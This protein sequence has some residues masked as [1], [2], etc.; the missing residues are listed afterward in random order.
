MSGVLPADHRLRVPLNDE[1]HARPPEPLEAPSRLSYLVLLSDAA[2]R[3]AGFRAICGL[4]ARFDAP[5]PAEGANH[6]RADL[7]PFRLKWERHSEFVRYT[8]IV[9]GGGEETALSSVPADWVAALPGELLVA[10][11]VTLLAAGTDEPFELAARLFARE[12]LVGAAV[13][14]ESATAFADFRIRESGFSRMLVRDDHLTPAQAGRIVQRLL[15]IDTYRMMALLALP[16][17]QE[18]VPALAHWEQELAR[19]TASMV[20]ATDQDEP[21]LLGGLTRL[22]AEIDSRQ[23]DNLYRFSATAAYYDLVKQRIADLRETRLGGLQTFQ[24]FTE[25]RLA[26]AANTCRSVAARQEELSRRV[27]RATQL[28]ATRVGITH[29]QQNQALLQSVNRRI[30]LQLRLQAT[31]EGLSVAAVTYYVAGL[32]GYAARGLEAA[33][34]RIDPAVAMAVAVPVVALAMG[35]GL[36]RLRRHVTE[37]DRP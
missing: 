19:I 21:E 24:E 32:V 16:V 26:P 33:G 35:L 18:L 20:A 9:P 34:M 13:A 37:A 6:Y 7:G 23:A 29:E 22:S 11:H 28:L 27:A 25:R 30:R 5:V 10:T 3:E 4:A 2:Q 15:E 8:V 12:A 14:G 31:V 36:W 17:A 1:V